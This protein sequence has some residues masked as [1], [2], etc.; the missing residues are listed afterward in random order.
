MTQPPNPPSDP[1]DSE[2]VSVVLVAAGRGQRLRES[3][4]K[5]GFVGQVGRKA[6]V[7]ILGQP[8][9]AWTLKALAAVPTVDNLVV[10]LHADDMAD[11]ALKE[12][13]KSWGATH[14][15]EGGRRRQ[16]SVLNGLRATPDDGRLVGVHDAARPLIHPDDVTAVFAGARE[17]GASVLSQRAT[18]TVKQSKDG[19]VSQTLPREM[20][21]LAQT[22]QVARREVLINALMQDFEVTDEAM[23]LEQLGAAVRIVEA[24]HPNPKVTTAQDKDLVEFL[25]RKQKELEVTYRIGEGSDIHRLV[26]GRKLVLGGVEVPYEY[27]PLGHSDGDVVLHSLVDA[28]LG[29]AGLGDIGELFPDTDPQHK[30]AASSVFVAEAM[31]RVRGLGLEVINADITILAE[32]P[33]LSPWK[34][35]IR[36]SVATLLGLSD[37]QAVNIKAKTNEGLDAIGRKEALAARASVLLQK[38]S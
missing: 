38:S 35:A 19:W 11:E 9:I 8:L 20:I 28:L 23:A 1:T 32:R 36:E 18:S 22:P 13:L 25:L 12:Q 33:K 27:G 3:L 16:D 4:V 10:V 34:S 30:D 24:Q 14:F 29:A 26:E 21:F 6:F 2:A 5:R 17:H 37:V 7:S 31:K 15:T